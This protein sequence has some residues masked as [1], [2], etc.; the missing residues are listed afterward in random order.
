MIIVLTGEKH[1]GDEAACEGTRYRL[2]LDRLG[3]EEATPTGRHLPHNNM[4]KENPLLS[5]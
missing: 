1:D 2:H 3:T 4:P 5:E